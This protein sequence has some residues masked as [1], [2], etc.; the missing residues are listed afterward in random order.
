MQLLKILN[1]LFK[2]EIRK[3]FFLLNIWHSLTDNLMLDVYVVLLWSECVH[4]S[5][6][7]KKRSD[8]YSAIAFP[9]QDGTPNVK[10]AINDAKNLRKKKNQKKNNEKQWKGKIYFKFIQTL[11]RCCKIRL[12][13]AV[14]IAQILLNFNHH[15]NGC[16]QK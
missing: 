12:V 15:I 8:L 1:T 4:F 6:W 7:K 10:Y 14:T 9:S 2:R 5:F 16:N 11:Y 3:V 13:K